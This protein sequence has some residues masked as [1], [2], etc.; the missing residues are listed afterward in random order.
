MQLTLAEAFARALA[1]ERRGDPKRA[2]AIYDDILAAIPEH[3]GALLGIAR[4]ARARRDPVEA[5]ALLARA[6]ASA[7]TM[8]S[9]FNLG[10]PRCEAA[11]LCLP[12]S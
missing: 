5:R 8:H 6:V 2:R 3:A 12:R 9:Q 7:R 10:A 1:A 4:Q 11:R